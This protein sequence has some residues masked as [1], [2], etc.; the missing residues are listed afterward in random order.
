MIAHMA[1]PLSAA[2]AVITLV[3]VALQSST[4]LYQAVSSFQSN[5]RAVRELKEELEA[6]GIVLKSLQETLEKP[7]IDLNALEHPLRRCNKACHDFKVL[8]EKHTLRSDGNRSSF[9]DWAKLKYLG[10]DIAGFKN[11]LAGYKSTIAIALGD[12]NM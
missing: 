5:N 12:A 1:D 6:L 4:L 2:S 11:M 8:I 7:D 3:V 9:R 10:Q